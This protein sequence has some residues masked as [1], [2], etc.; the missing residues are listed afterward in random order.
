M[1][2]VAQHNKAQMTPKGGGTIL[3]QKTIV[4]DSMLPP[5]KELAMLKEIK[6]E[7]VDWVMKKAE[8]EQDA[9]IEFNKNRIMLAKKDLNGK[10]WVNI[11][12]LI[13]AFMIVIVGIV[14]TIW[15]LKEGLT[16]AG[17]IFAGTTLVGAAALFTQIPK[18]H[19]KE[20]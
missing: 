6:P 10:I 20:N 13:F 14:A 18:N 19:T 16:V 8:K 1:T 17:T 15:A 12:S 4:D 11:I 2:K 7:L 3:E 9:R 5:A